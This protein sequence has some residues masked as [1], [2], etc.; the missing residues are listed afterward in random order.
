MMKSL[1]VPSHKNIEINQ[2]ALVLIFGC[3]FPQNQS[4]GS[5]FAMFLYAPGESKKFKSLVGC[6][7]K[8]MR[9]IYKIEMLIYQRLS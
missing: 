3:L 9:P 7:M 5:Y 6:G 4:A 2:S 1:S 8:R